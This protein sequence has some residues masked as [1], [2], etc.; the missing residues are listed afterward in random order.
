[1]IPD[2]TLAATCAFGLETV[3]ARELKDLGAVDVQQDNGSVRFRGDLDLIC[4][5]NLWLRSADRLWIHLGRFRATTFEDLFQGVK[6][7]PWGDLLSKDSAFPVDGASHESQLSSV[8]ACQAVSKKAIV[9]AMKGRWKTDWFA[10]TGATFR[11]RVSIVR[12]EVTVAVDTSG[13]GL[14]RRGYRKLTA[15]APLRETLAAGLVL[16]S[17]WNAERLLVDPFCG[18]GTIPIEAALIGLKRAPGLRRAFASE[19]WPFLGK[20]RWKRARE[21]AEDAF[22]RSARLDIHGYDADPEVLS[23][24]RYHLRESGLDDRGIDFQQ[25]RVQDFSTKRRYGVIVTNPPYGERMSQLGEVEGLYREL[26]RVMAPHDTW[27]TFVLTSHP[28]FDR[29]F[30]QSVT[31][32]RKLYNGMIQCTYYQ[33]LGQKPPRLG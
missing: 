15:E 17:V 9:E 14:H 11:V 16:L 24:A 5:G 10:E 31:R 28:R 22:D 30:G 1:L 32:K 29:L 25:R 4:R 13:R 20:A 27:S 21:E 8:P 3:V 12:D 7:L 19:D 33:F 18:S 6:A 26:G 23:L 2:L